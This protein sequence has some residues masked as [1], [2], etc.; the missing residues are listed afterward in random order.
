ME[1]DVSVLRYFP[2]AVYT[3]G[4]CYYGHHGNPYKTVEVIADNRQDAEKKAWRELKP[5]IVESICYVETKPNQ[6][7]IDE[8]E[9]WLKARGY[10]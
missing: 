5:S 10:A 1:T 2:T 6:E 3:F 8:Q 9:R 7:F 4:L